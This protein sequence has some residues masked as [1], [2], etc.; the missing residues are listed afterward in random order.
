MAREGARLFLSARKTDALKNLADEIHASGGKV[1]FEKVDVENQEEI[2]SYVNRVASRTKSIDAVFNA[3][4]VS[5]NHVG[6]LCIPSTG[7]N[8]DQFLEYTNTVVLS[9]FLTAQA[10]AKHMLKQGSGVVIFLTATPA[11]G[12]APFMIG[13]SAGHAAIEGMIRS[14][15][16]EWGPMGLRVVGIRSGGMPESR[17]IKEV[18]TA[19]SKIAGAPAD[20]FIKAAQEKPLLKRMPK[21]T[22]TANVV[23]FLASDYASSLTASITNSSCGEVID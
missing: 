1:E 6:N 22:E 9:Q 20:D 3:V 2:A 10:A 4:G 16:T 11:K 15:A 21:L 12:V 5:S 23:A 14:L 18:L 19:M 7:V 8:S 17:R 13:H